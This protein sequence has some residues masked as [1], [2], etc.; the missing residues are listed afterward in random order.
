MNKEF[1]QMYKLILQNQSNEE[2]YN[3]IKPKVSKKDYYN[4]ISTIRKLIQ[5]NPK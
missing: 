2:V 4:T 1:N 3:T 5:I